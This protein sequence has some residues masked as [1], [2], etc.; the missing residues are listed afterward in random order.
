MLILERIGC[1]KED[2]INQQDNDERCAQVQIMKDI[3][4]KIN[5][6][7]YLVREIYSDAIVTIKFACLRNDTM[8]KIWTRSGNIIY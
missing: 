8:D 5:G 4:I 7:S 3:Y 1:S 2:C 6:N